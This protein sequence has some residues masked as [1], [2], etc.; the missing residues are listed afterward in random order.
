MDKAA[1]VDY[2]HSQMTHAMLFTGVHE[3]NKKTMRW[4]VENSWGDK[5]GKKG[6]LVMGDAWFDEYVF[7]IAVHKKLVDKELLK[8]LDKSPTILAPWDPMGSLA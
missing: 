8:E 4:K 2:G 5:K 6:F 1:R 7:Q 3:Q